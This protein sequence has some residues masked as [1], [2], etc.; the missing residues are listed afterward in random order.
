MR[1]W[2]WRAP[3]AAIAAAGQWSVNLA[4]GYGSLQRV[5]PVLLLG[6]GA[7]G[8]G[9]LLEHDRK[10]SGGTGPVFARLALVYLLLGAGVG[11][12]AAWGTQWDDGLRDP[13][14]MVTLLHGLLPVAGVGLA[15]GAAKADEALWG[16]TAYGVGM[17]GGFYATFPYVSPLTLPETTLV[18][19][20]NQA[21]C[22]G[23]VGSGL[24]GVRRLFRPTRAEEWPIWAAAGMS[25]GIMIPAAILF[26]R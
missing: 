24:H 7:A 6:V 11:S 16:G 26:S 23:A 4:P 20:V 13:A 15:F 2:A 10:R 14:V 22:F 18:Y 5:I 17:L 25:L 19:V 12:W 3:L 21:W 9:V 8:L 1:T